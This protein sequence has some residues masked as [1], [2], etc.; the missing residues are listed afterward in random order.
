M[1]RAVTP[2]R[3]I[4]PKHNSGKAKLTEL[5]KDFKN[6]GLESIPKPLVHMLESLAKFNSQLP[7]K[8]EEVTFTLTFE[9]KDKSLVTT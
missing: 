5:Q 7:P 6:Q 9:S 2:K 4:E 8:T 1:C 3:M